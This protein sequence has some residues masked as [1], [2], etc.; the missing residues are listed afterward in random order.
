[1]SVLG[2]RTRV[3]E[4]DGGRAGD[5]LVLIHGVGGWA[6][7]FRPVMK[8]LAATG[9]RVV[10]LDLPGFGESE[11]PR[12]KVKYFGPDDA[13]YPRFVIAAMDALGIERAHLVGNS[14]GG[15]VAYMTAVTAPERT[16]SLVLA[17]AGGIGLDVAFFLRACAFPGFGLIARLPRSPRTARR[18]LAT[19]F[20]DP[21]RIPEEMLREAERYGG[22]SFP[23]FVRALAAGVGLRGVRRDLRD[24]WIARAD[25]FSGPVLVLWGREDRVLPVTHVDAIHAVVPRA[26]V[27]IIERCGHLPMAERPEEFLAATLPFLDR[28]EKALAA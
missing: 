23:E 13:F 6:E 9:R 20:H 19:C 16:R 3:I 1:M 2:L 21:A 27:R 18:V 15:A 25:R 4:S 8:P 5:P 24:A 12:A 17:A 28:A 11:R 14:M 22:A 10:A 7:N 26:E